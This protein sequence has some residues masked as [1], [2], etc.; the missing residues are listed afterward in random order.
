MSLLIRHS[1]LEM[2]FCTNIALALLRRDTCKIFLY[3][4]LYA[5]RILENEDFLYCVHK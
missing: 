5:T 2:L 4:L 1:K 3:K